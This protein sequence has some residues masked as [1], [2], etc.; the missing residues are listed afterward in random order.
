[1]KRSKFSK[2]QVINILKQHEQGVKVTDICREH[3]ISVTI[4]HNWKAK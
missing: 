4:F 1:M 3:G 2:T